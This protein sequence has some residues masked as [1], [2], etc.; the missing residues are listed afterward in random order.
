MVGRPTPARAATPSIVKPPYPCS[1]RTSRVAAR[2]ASS[3]LASRGRPGARATWPGCM[4]G[5]SLDVTDELLGGLHANG[6]F[7]LQPLAYSKES[8]YDYDSNDTRCSP[9]RIA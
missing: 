1:P 4:E 5:E 6:Q 7:T 8:A 2:I 9:R 3:R